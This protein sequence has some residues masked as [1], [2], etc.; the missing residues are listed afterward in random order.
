MPWRYHPDRPSEGNEHSFDEMRAKLL[1]NAACRDCRLLT[2]CADSAWN[3]WGGASS[4]ILT[5]VH[6]CGACRR[7][8]LWHDTDTAV[9]EVPDDC[10]RYGGPNSFGTNHVCSD[11]S[12]RGQKP[13][14]WPEVERPT[15]DEREALGL[16]RRT[17]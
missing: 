3:K 10:P 15:D 11:C 12:A 5:D 14:P 13:R 8:M 1:E 16:P 7:P 9:F 17:A 4:P 2:Y 6:N